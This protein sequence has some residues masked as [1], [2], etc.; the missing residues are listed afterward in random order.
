MAN[1][2]LQEK[3]EDLSHKLLSQISSKKT[4]EA[5]SNLSELDSIKLELE[6]KLSERGE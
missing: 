6:K 2:A 1:K 4:V 3:K 5:A